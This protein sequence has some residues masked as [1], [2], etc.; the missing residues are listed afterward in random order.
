MC[1]IVG[2]ASIRPE[3]DGEWL[4]RAT[5]ALAHRGPDADG[6]FRSSDGRVGLGHRRLSVIDLS[7]L[8]DQPMH[9]EGSATIVFNGEIYNFLDLRRELSGMGHRFRSQSDT[10]VVLAAYAQWG[11]RCVTRLNGMFAFAI[12]DQDRDMIYLARDRAGEK[13]LFY[14]QSKGRLWFG[15]ELK[16]LLAAPQLPRRIDPLALD[17]FL[18]FRFVPGERCILEGYNKLPPAHAMTFDLGTGDLNVFRY[19]SLPQPSQPDTRSAGADEELL[20]ALEELLE[21]SVRRQLVADVPVG[22]LLS[23]GVDSSVVTA[24]AARSRSQISTFTVGFPGHGNMNELPHARIVADRFGTQ[25]HELMA[26]AGIDGLLPR[27]ARQLD[28]PMVDSSIIPT[29]L[30]SELIRQHCTVAIGGDGGDE[31]FGGYTHYSH[32]LRMARRVGWIP[33]AVRRLAAAVIQGVVP[34]GRRGRSFAANL[35]TDYSSGLPMWGV[36]FDQVTRARLI[37]AS[38]FEMSIGVETAEAVFSARVPRGRDLLDRATRMDF[39][40]Y[41]AEDIL[42]KVD[43][44]SMLTSLEVRAPLLDYRVVEFAFDRVPSRLKTSSREKK[45]LLKRLARRLLPSELDLDR[46]QGFSVPLAAWLRTPPVRDLFWDVLTDPSCV[47]NK[48]LAMELLTSHQGGR[49]NAE[50]LFALVMFEMWRSE[51]GAHF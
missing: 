30:V 13:P 12:Y 26:E 23:G 19:W 39:T 38:A 15:S 6:L 33:S 8:A 37:G 7:R 45:I 42:V 18:A 28:E 36:L 46:K 14:R 24:L 47:F 29:F 11:E 40:D 49:D 17:C 50:R 31:L 34:I 21:D 25:H 3:S 4:T 16:A 5:E 48:R 22:I 2:F 35:A 32:M 44:A 41:L 51:Y 27:L 43:R 1:G 10:E 9:R 20:D